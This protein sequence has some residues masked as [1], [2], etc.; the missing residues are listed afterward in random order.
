MT[1]LGRGSGCVN[2]GGEKV[3]PEEVE[4]ALK[5]HPAVADAL[6]VGVPD[7]EWG[8]RVA[9]VVELEVGRGTTG[10]DLDEWLAAKLASYK[11]PREIAIVDDVRRSPV[12]KPDYEWARAVLTR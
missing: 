12:G 5:A 9:A 1:L 7:E 10:P 8:Q 11:R 2:T 6:V 4:E 3:W